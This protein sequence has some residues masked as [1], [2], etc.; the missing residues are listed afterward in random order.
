MTA[1][2]SEDR[3]GTSAQR[4]PAHPTNSDVHSKKPVRFNAFQM[5]TPSHQSPGLWR[6]PRN[7]SAGYASAGYW[8]ELA[9]LLER[10]GFDAIFLADVLGAYDVYGGSLDAALKHG[11]QLP[12]NDPLALVPLIAHATT[13]LGIGVT[14][15]VTY[16]HP[17]TFARR[18]STL[19]HLSGGR[20]GWN[21]VTGYLHSAARNLG[22][23]RQLG[24]DQR[25]DLA[26]EYLDVVY[27]LWEKS[28]DEDA[29]LRDRER[30]V[31]TDPSRVHPIN[32]QGQYYTVPGI[33]L[34]EPSPQR[35]PFLYQAGASK[36]GLAF[37]ARHAEATF[38]SGPTKGIV[39]RY[40]DS[41]RAAAQAAGR[42]PAAL[43][44]YAQALVVVGA[45]EAEAQARLREYEEYID[46]EASLTL[47]SGWTGVD[48]SRYGLDD[49]VEYIDT[50]AGRSALASLSVADPARRWTVRE[51]ARFIGLGGRGPVIVGDAAQVADQLV[52]WLDETGIDGFNLAFALP[53][54]DMQGVV[55]LV[56]PELKRRG[57]YRQDKDS[58]TL[59]E[60]LLGA[61]PRLALD[62]PGRQVSI[63][64]SIDTA[65][66]S[67]A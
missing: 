33:H 58:A 3:V 7:D 48:F 32:H 29:V 56:V 12:L 64:K 5:N 51:A 35:T 30:G 45:T 57:R 38:V 24:H 37:A 40:V 20:I 9:Q 2:L 6:H 52:D 26:D 31:Y 55:E 18:M 16:E 22:Q 49:T 47:L 19:D 53:Y 11:V 67:A 14:A 23:E 61:G 8:V 41:A 25:Y 63:D 62:H 15:A 34:C 65:L 17:Y 44:V 27:K 39:Q 42:D 66:R 21:I 59:R 13:R 54:E 4:G 60:Q 10:G 50:E 1:D 46:I 28:W 36:R 43:R